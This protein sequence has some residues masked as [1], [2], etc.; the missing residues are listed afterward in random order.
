MEEEDVTLNIG[1]KC[2]T[3]FNKDTMNFLNWL[4]SFEYLLD[5]LKIEDDDKGKFLLSMVEPSI[6]QEIEE[7][8]SPTNPSD[9]PYDELVSELEAMFG[10]ASGFLAANYR[11]YTRE[12]FPGEPINHY[13]LA[14]RKL[15]SKCDFTVRKWTTLKKRFISGLADAETKA[16]LKQQSEEI[17]LAVAV[18]IAMQRKSASQEL[19]ENVN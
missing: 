4:N 17:T 16:L 1:E 10:S 11:F 8:L 13:V 18:A 9:L 6:L 19:K 14:L 15:F 7:K 2:I 5:I 12:Q 3:K